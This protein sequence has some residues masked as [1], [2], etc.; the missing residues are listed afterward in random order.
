MKL[1]TSNQQDPNCPP[2]FTHNNKEISDH[3]TIANKLCEI[4]TNM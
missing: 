4:L 3:Y 2:T 1:L